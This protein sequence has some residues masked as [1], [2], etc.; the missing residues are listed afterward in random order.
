MERNSFAWNNSGMT[1]GMTRHYINQ[2]ENSHQL[3]HWEGLLSVLSN[4]TSHLSSSHVVTSSARSSWEISRPNQR[5][6][7][8]RLSRMVWQTAG[9]ARASWWPLF[10]ASSPLRCKSPLSLWGKKS[11]IWTTSQS[12]VS[13]MLHCHTSGCIH[14]APR[15][16]G[17]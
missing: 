10:T 16:V 4:V 13:F 15:S 5:N 11:R 9:R 8:I 12:T 14:R 17:Y 7:V 1:S 3:L 2:T 6:K